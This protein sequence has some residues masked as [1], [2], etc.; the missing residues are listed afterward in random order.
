MKCSDE[1]ILKKIFDIRDEEISI[2]NEDDRAFM[3]Q[4]EVSRSKKYD[5][6][7]NE[8]EKINFKSEIEK[9][10]VFNLLEK[11]VDSIDCQS[12]Y[13]NEKYYFEG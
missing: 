8:L 9:E 4:E 6:L 13:F 3:E 7:R 1:S 2:L 5:K 11:Y 10:R 12:S